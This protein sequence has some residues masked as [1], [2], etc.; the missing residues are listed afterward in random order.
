MKIY[1]IQTLIV[2][3]LTVFNIGSFAQDR[4]TLDT[5][6]A[7]ILAQMP[8]KD[9]VHRDRVMNEIVELGPEG[10]QKISALL[11]APG[12][13]DDTAVRFALNSL[14]RYVSQFGKEAEKDFVETQLLTALGKPSDKMVMTF[15]LTQLNLVGGEKLWL[16]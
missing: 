3:L 16:R 11:V 6:V 1:K 7:D 13:G 9:L 4:R 12:T 8:T 5:K 10:F 15:L 2:L 14:S